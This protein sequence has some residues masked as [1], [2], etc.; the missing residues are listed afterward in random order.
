MREECLVHLVHLGKVIHS[1]KED[2]NLNDLAEAGTGLLENGGKVVDAECG[3][4]GDVG[5][6]KG[7]DVAGWG[8]GDLA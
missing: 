2:V 8:A 7:Q 1:R 5:G 4:L 6:F 3:H